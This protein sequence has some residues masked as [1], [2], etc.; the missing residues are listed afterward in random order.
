MFF[1]DI[2]LNFVVKRPPNLP[3]ATS[4]AAIFLQLLIGMII[5]Q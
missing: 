5:G 1:S 3:G 2:L 4:N